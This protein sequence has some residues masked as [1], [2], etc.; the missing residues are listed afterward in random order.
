MQTRVIRRLMGLG[1]A[2]GCW[3][4]AGTAAADTFYVANQN[5]NNIEKFSASG[6]DLGVFAS[7]GV[8]TP[9]GIALDSSNNIYL[10]NVGNNTVTKYSASGSYLG[11]F[12]QAGLSQPVGL[13][14]DGSGNLY[15]G[16]FANNTIVRYSASGSNLGVFA[17]SGVYRPYGLA[18]DSSGQLYV[19]NAV[20]NTVEK[21][22][23]SGTDLGAFASTNLNWPSSLAFDSSGNLYVGNWNSDTVEKFSASGTD[24]GVFVS[25]G[26]NT[27]AGLAFDRSDNLYVVY[28][29]NMIRKYSES[30]TDLGV[31]SMS[32]MYEPVSIAIQLDPGSKVSTVAHPAS[33]GSI[34]GGGFYAPGSNV[35]LTAAASNGWLFVNWNDGTTN[36][37]KAFTASTTNITYTAYFLATNVDRFALSIIS[38]NQAA[39]TPFTVSIAALNSYGATITVYQAATTLSAAGAGG[40]DALQPLTITAWTNGVWTGLV[41]VNTLDTN[42]LLTA[43]DGAG[44]TGSSNPFTVQVGPVDHFVWAAVASPQVQGVPFPVTVIAQDAAS[45]TV[46]GFAGPVGLSGGTNLVQNGGFE[47]GDFAGWTQAGNTGAT[48][49][50]GGSPSYVH[51]GSRGA[52]LGPVGS[53]GYLTQSL[54]TTPGAS[55]LVSF[56]FRNPDLATPNEFAATWNGTNLFDQTNMGQFGWTNLQYTVTANGP[57]AVLQFGFRNDPDFFGFDDISVRAS[58]N[59]TPTDSGTFSGG[60]WTGAVT[61][62]QAGT[63]VVLV[64][65]DG[66]GHTGTSA[67]FDV[68]PSVMVTALAGPPGAGNVTGGGI[69]AVGSNAVLTATAA[70][71]WL[72]TGWDDGTTNN[73]YAI[74]VPATNVTY[75][76]MFAPA[77]TITVAANTNAGGSVT[78]GGIFFVGS[79]DVL[80]ATAFNGWRFTGW[81]DGATNNP[82]AITVPATNITYT[83]DFT[84]APAQLFFQAGNGQVAALLVDTNGVVQTNRLLGST[85]VWQLRAAG[86]VDG[87]GIS[88]LLFQT[89]AGDTAGWFLKA[90]G[91]IRSVVQW[92]QVGAWKLCAC[93]DY[94]GE[95]HAQI[96][97]QHPNGPVAFWHIDTNGV[98]Q[99]AELVLTNAGPWHLRAAIPHAAGGRADLFWQT[100]TSLVAVWQQQSGGGVTAQL[101]GSTVGWTLCAAVD[102]DNDGVGDL[103]WQTPDDL[104]GGWF[105][106]SNS[107]FR[108]AEYWWSTSGWTLKAAGR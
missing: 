55:F 34:T 31:F 13:A 88:D 60:V 24:L 108:S 49:V 71:G 9:Y 64:A 92:G 29:N 106:N 2:A 67:A 53:L 50:G 62:L 101:I 15:V 56:W 76:A 8:S 37:T 100:D 69:C 77:A 95:G 65:D 16:N 75:T 85:G 81:N 89:A 80:R 28:L 74:T 38:S 57:N 51:S 22:S 7:T 93:A 10:A 45:N 105:M 84:P 97:F 52:G 36:N 25:S 12:A 78:G 21:F 26:I 91:S 39:G 48:F 30:G 47:T 79:N 43:S 6:T 32:G 103:L 17:S 18:F 44:H 42:V 99:G 3:V 46:T 5:Y 1:L 94:V 96:F 82:Y 33:G 98:F 104:V 11:V 54:A 40:A 20:S 19:A 59:L 83:A 68:Q 102:V 41:R 4:W 66:A 14:F 70:T 87:D 107:T 63:N 23:A 35:V 58:L 90:D 61:V 86:D 72:Y 27:P 73:P